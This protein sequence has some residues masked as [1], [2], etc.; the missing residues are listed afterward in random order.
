MF[1]TNKQKNPDVVKNKYD[2]FK[3]F[4]EVKTTLKRMIT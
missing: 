3:Y 1:F 2:L 4:Y